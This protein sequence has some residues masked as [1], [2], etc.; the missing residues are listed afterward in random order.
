[1]L[2]VH[3]ADPPGK[4]KVNC[5]VEAFGLGT[6]WPLPS[7]MLSGSLVCEA[8]RTVGAILLNRIYCRLVVEEIS[9][10]SSP[11]LACPWL[12]TGLG[13]LR[14]LGTMAADRVCFPLLIPDI[15]VTHH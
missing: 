15:F 8:G 3:A 10:V 1:M 4:G 11:G 5:V 9:K 12:A 6:D 14:R 7:L 2:V 13:S